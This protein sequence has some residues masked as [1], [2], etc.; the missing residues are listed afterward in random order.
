MVDENC[1]APSLVSASHTVKLQLTS[2]MCLLYLQL[3]TRLT[4][5]Y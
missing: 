2:T 1:V 5:D 4:R 3:T